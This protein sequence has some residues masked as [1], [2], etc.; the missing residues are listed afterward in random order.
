MWVVLSRINARKI[1]LSYLYQQCFFSKLKNDDLVLKDSLFADNVFLSDNELYDEEKE[2]FLS[3]IESYFWHDLDSEVDY[4]VNHFFDKWKVEDI[5]VD[6]IFKI[7]K[8][9]TKHINE[10]ESEVNKYA[11]SFSYESMWVMTKCIF[12]LAYTEW[13]EMDTD[14]R[15]LLN[16]TVELAKRYNDTWS[17]KLI[18]AI[19]HRIFADS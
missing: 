14:K 15:I 13:K 16:E 1:V 6:Y 7:L 4:F 10:L 19:L 3:E 9:Y 12:M 2:N 8:N 11:D 18:N 5:D 17:A